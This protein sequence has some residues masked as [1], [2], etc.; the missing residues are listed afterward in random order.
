L[1]TVVPKNVILHA[2][3]CVR[4][5]ALQKRFG[6]ILTGTSFQAFDIHST[7]TDTDALFIFPLG[8]NLHKIPEIVKCRLSQIFWPTL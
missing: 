1:F 7:I 8:G 6:I 3:F 2:I 5:T 4:Q